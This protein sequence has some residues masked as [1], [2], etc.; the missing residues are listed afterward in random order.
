MSLG[1]ISPHPHGSLHS[2]HV[3]FCVP[4]LSVLFQTGLLGGHLVLK[5]DLDA[6]AKARAPGEQKPVGTGAKA[7]I[8]VTV[9]SS[10][11][12]IFDNEAGTGVGIEVMMA[13]APEEQEAFRS[14]VGSDSFVGALGAA[15]AE[16]GV[17]ASAA[18]A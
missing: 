9:L 14:A 16:G 6:V 7:A 8:P 3:W 17:V 10:S 11:E 1:K 12:V 15:W 18:E 2:R 4:P 5:A 13:V